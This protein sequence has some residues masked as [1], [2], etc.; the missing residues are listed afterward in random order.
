VARGNGTRPP[1][2]ALPFEP[3]AADKRK[4]PVWGL[5]RANPPA[6]PPKKS[7]LDQVRILLEEIVAKGSG[8]WWRLGV[9]PSR[10]AAAHMAGR[11]RKRHSSTEWQFEAVSVPE[12]GQSALYARWLA[13]PGEERP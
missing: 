1:D 9:F 10:T 5:V 11:L 6:P 3:V 13:A 8:E 4:G 2:D 7:Q 12:V